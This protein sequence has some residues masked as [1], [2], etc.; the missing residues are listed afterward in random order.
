[1]AAGLK[2]LELIERDRVIEKTTK[3]AEELA[4]RLKRLAEEHQ[5]DATV[6]QVAS[7]LQ[8]FFTGREV[9]SYRDAQTSNLERFRRFHHHLREEGVYWAPAQFET[10]FLSA[11][12]TERDLEA[13]EAA[14]A[15]ALEGVGEA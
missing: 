4:H 12:H 9:W 6:N 15:R 13:T 2:T 8:L 3:L 5:V 11:A 14:L 7:M 10:C 1:M